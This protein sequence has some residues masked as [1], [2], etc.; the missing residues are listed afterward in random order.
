[1]F[2]L[3]SAFRLIEQEQLFTADHFLPQKHL[4]ADRYIELDG[5][6]ENQ[7]AEIV[8][9]MLQAISHGAAANVPVIFN[10]TGQ[11]FE[12]L[13]IPNE[14]C[15]GLF[16]SGT[17]GP[18]KLVFHSLDKLLPKNRKDKNTISRWL[19]CY[20]PMSYAG[21]QVIL[22][23]VVANDTLVAD[24]GANIQQKAQLALKHKINAISATPSLMR[25]MLLCWCDDSPLFELITLGGEISDQTTL[26]VL[27]ERFPDAVIRHIYATTETGVIFS[28]KDGREGFPKQWLNKTFN[29]WQLIVRDTLVLAHHEHEIETGDCIDIKHDRAVFSGRKDSVVNVGG[30]KVDLEDIERQLIALVEVTDARV[31]VKANPITGVLVCAEICIV[32]DNSAKQ[33]INNFCQQLEAAARPRIITFCE[34]LTLSTAGKKQRCL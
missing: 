32:N 17:T 4:V 8:A 5:E 18:P 34:Q 13:E 12:H 24:T 9:N 30:V 3:G 26:D 19:L 14:F 7:Q 28:V 6:N 21:L 11:T 33:A 27:K 20:H 23:A 29:G 16:T 2:S 15:I 22:Q 31:Y 25:G 10:R 1:M